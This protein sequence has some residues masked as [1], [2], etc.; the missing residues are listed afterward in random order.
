MNRGPV[1]EV[2]VIADMEGITGCSSYERE[3]YPHC[4]D[5]PRA[6]ESLIADLRAALDGARSAGADSFA[7]YDVHYS[8]D[9]LVGADLGDAV[10]LYAGKP[11]DNGLRRGQ[12]GLFIVGLHA[13]A[14]NTRGVLPHS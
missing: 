3:L 8:G 5:Y 9:N 7:I 14:G 4:P 12:A 1:P 10:T 11:Q 13:M 6:R 2:Y